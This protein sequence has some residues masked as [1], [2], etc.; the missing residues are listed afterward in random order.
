MRISA[1]EDE[2]L[3]I[4]PDSEFDFCSFFRHEKSPVA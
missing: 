1:P 2:P 3:G 4:D